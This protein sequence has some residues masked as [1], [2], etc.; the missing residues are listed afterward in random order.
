MTKWRRA[1]ARVA[2]AVWLGYF[3]IGRI[4]DTRLR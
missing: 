4:I 3:G 2:G 1:Q